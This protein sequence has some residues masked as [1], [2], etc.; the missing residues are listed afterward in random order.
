MVLGVSGKQLD[1]NY[2]NA[3]LPAISIYGFNIKDLQNM[4]MAV[5]GEIYHV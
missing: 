3:R 1:F 4:V 5:N 2:R